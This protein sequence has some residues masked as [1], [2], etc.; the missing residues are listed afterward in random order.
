MLGEYTTMEAGKEERVNYNEISNE[1]K[2]ALKTLEDSGPG[3]KVYLSWESLAWLLSTI[4]K[5]EKEIFSLKQECDHREYS[6]ALDATSGGSLFVVTKG[7]D[8]VGVYDTKETAAIVNGWCDGDV[9]EFG[10]NEY[11]SKIK[12]G[13][14]PWYILVAKNGY[15]SKIGRASTDNWHL[16]DKEDSYKWKGRFEPGRL[17]TVSFTRD[18]I[19]IYTFAKDESHAVSIATIRWTKAIRDGEFE[20]NKEEYEIT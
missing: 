2:E 7:K 3:C 10:L 4:A 6:G 20:K 15:I 13:L 8:V 5:G 16:C 18:Q 12:K 9:D 14:S 1:Y 19:G 11:S 17:C